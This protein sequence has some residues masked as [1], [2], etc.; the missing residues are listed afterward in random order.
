MK[1][2]AKWLVIGAGLYI[3]FRLFSPK[4]AAS[5]PGLGASGGS[6]GVGGDSGGPDFGVIDPTSG[7]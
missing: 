6:T 4:S 7:W 1:K 2:Y 5:V 3:A